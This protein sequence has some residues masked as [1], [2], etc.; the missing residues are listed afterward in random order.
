MDAETGRVALSLRERGPGHAVIHALLSQP[1]MLRPRGSVAR[2]FGLSPLTE[3]GKPWYQGALGEIAVGKM[4][5][6]LGPRWVVMHALPVGKRGSDIDHLVVGSAGVFTINTK[7]HSRQRVWVMDRNVLVAGQR[8]D[9]VRNGEF[10]ASRVAKLLGAVL[11]WPVPVRSIVAVVD[12]ARLDIK[13]QPAGVEVLEAHR[14]VRSLKKRRPV[15]TGEELA[16]IERVVGAPVTWRYQPDDEADL[17]RR[18]AFKD[19]QSEIRRAARRR[20][21]WATGVVGAVVLVVLVTVTQ[22]I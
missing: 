9:H 6:K 14:L 2:L 12:S 7:N 3:Q 20:V 13:Q 5:S 21:M 22:L 11:G 1:E 10:E 4:L 8:S 18:Q 15:L 17:D 16:R 19:L